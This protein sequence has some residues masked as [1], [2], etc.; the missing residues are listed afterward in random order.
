MVDI[1]NTRKETIMR[2]YQETDFGKALMRLRKD[3][4]VELL[5]GAIGQVIVMEELRRTIEFGHCNF[6]IR[7]ATKLNK[8]GFPLYDYKN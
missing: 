1:I 5:E 7:V 6:C 4:L 3:E 8:L 2:S